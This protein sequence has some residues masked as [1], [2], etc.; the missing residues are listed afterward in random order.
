[1][2]GVLTNMLKSVAVPTGLRAVLAAAAIGAVP[3]AAL[4]DH[5]DYDRPSVHVDLGLHRSQQRVEERADRVWI[6]PVYR[7]VTDRQWVEPVYRTVYDHV[8]VPPVTQTVI[9]RVWVPQ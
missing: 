1:M 6:E 5:H 4:A 3:A 9:D 2:I 7:T 8:W